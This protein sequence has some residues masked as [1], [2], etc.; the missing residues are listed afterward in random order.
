MRQFLRSD[1]RHPRIETVPDAHGFELGQKRDA[2]SHPAEN[3]FLCFR[4][5]PVVTSRPQV[6]GAGVRPVL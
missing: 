3:A 2:F 4:W 6:P 1:Q 5:S